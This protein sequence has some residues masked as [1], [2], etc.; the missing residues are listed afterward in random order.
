MACFGAVLIYNDEY[1]L[2]PLLAGH[3]HLLLLAPEMRADGHDIKEIMKVCGKS[4]PFIVEKALRQAKAFIGSVGEDF[5]G[6]AF[7]R[8]EN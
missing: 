5:I 1:Q 8:L 2:L 4:H 3:F 6:F 7:S